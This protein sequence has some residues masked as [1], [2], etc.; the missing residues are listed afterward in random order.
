MG[1]YRSSGHPAADEPHAAREMPSGGTSEAR[2]APELRCWHRP[3]A[4]TPG[5]FIRSETH[6]VMSRWIASH[7]V[8]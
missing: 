3:A 5:R 7:R 4:P 6:C 2:H 8:R 1:A